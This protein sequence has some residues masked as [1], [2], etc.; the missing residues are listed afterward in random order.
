MYNG[1][2]L[3]NQM[4]KSFSRVRALSCYSSLYGNVRTRVIN[5]QSKIACF[6]NTGMLT[7]SL[8]LSRA[9]A[10]KLSLSQ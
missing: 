7:R 6:P 9:R 8:A 4:V 1:C 3:I 2:E 5:L 10:C